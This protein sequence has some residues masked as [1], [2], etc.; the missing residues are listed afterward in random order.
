[1]NN[2]TLPASKR[3]IVGKKT[4]FLRRQGITPAHLFGHDLK[5]LSLQCN[6]AELQQIIAQA[7][8]SRLIDLEIEDENKPRS[9]VIR[10][11]QRAEPGGQLLHVD[12][13]QVKKTEKMTVD[14][15]IILVGEAPA[16]KV[17][18]TLLTMGATSLSIECL[19]TNIP[20]QIDVDISSLAELD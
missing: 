2:L 14:I 17:K 9:V 4:R 20:P 13:Y 1:M 16:L 19:P 12:F 15:P 18:G 8:T 11:I 7:Q 10:E 3:D 5:S 6:T